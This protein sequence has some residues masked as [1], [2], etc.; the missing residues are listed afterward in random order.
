M[1]MD[2]DE[3]VV[4]YILIQF[5]IAAVLSPISY[6][7][8]KD[9]VSLIEIPWGLRKPENVLKPTG[10]RIHTIAKFCG[11]SSALLALYMLLFNKILLLLV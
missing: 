3:L 7:F 6:L 2:C 9:G 10:V 11:I 8:K 1:Q 4:T 5:L